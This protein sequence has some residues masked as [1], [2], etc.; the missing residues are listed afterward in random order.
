MIRPVGQAET[1]SSRSYYDLGTFLPLGR[2]AGSSF[3]LLPFGTAKFSIS[4]YRGLLL[5]TC[6]LL[7]GRLRLGVCGGTSSST[8]LSPSPDALLLSSAPA[9][10]LYKIIQN[11]TT[12]HSVSSGL[13][14]RHDNE[15][16]NTAIK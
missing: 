10:R 6:P 2:A 1:S 11:K 8:P 12:N 4:D 7:M 14:K 15:K 5:T 3:V 16:K 9:P 13:A